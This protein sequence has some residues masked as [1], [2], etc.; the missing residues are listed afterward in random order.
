M[1][2]I[3]SLLCVLVLIVSCT[4][5]PYY[6]VP[7]NADGSAYLT[8]VSST[9]TTGISTLDASFTVTATL[10]NAKAGD[11][12]SV[13]LLQPQTVTGQA[14]KQLL[15]LAGTQKTAT[16]GSDLKASVTYTR[17]EGQ[18]A[19]ATDY[20]TVV[21]NGV[22]DYAKVKIT[23]EPATSTTAPKVSGVVVEVA[24]TAETAYFN[25]TIAPKS[26]AYTGTLVVQSKNAKNDAFADVVGSPFAMATP[27]LVPITGTDFAVGHDTMFYTF[28]ATS[29]AYTDQIATTIIVRDPYFYLKKTA[30]L[31]RGG[32]TAA[33]N[34]LLNKGVAVT[35]TTGHLQIS[36]SGPLTLEGGAAWLAKDPVKHIIEFVPTTLATY[37]ANNST[38]T[39]AEFAAG[40]PTTSAN[41]TGSPAY[42]YRMVLGPLPTDVFYGLMKMGAANA[43]DGTVTIEFRIGNQY[44]HLAV[45]K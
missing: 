26:G 6:D 34:L 33:L 8:G 17:A 13:E 23:M 27:I 36:A 31:T 11:V 15:P 38:A 45:I 19:K 42:I 44:A 21:F 28:T 7:K 25:V 10:P 30:T 24:R 43:T 14:S 2:K 9:T 35:D 1:K 39:I 20:V 40:T 41:P 22:T 37:T 32:S 18:L 12:M 5:Q 29:G 16:V 4:K 3:I